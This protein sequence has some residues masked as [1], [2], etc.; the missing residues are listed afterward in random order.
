VRLADDVQVE[1]RHDVGRT[2]D[3]EGWLVVNLLLCFLVEDALANADAVV[4][5]VHAGAG[6]ELLHFCVALAAK[7]ANGEVGCARHAGGFF[8][9]R[10]C[11]T[12]RANGASV[13]FGP[14]N[15]CQ[16]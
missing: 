8:G 1:R 12:G 13:S 15:I 5:N 6:D 10:K 14:P 16:P 4:A 11:R 7:G 3:G 2:R 9:W